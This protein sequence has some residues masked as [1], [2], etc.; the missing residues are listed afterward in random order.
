MYE[1][2]LLILSYIL[3]SRPNPVTEGNRVRK[4]PTL[5]IKKLI[6]RIFAISEVDILSIRLA[7]VSS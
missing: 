1:G 4:Q 7:R 2:D 6:T 3:S 5:Q